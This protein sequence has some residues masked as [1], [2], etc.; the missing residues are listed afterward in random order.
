M[1]HPEELYVVKTRREAIQMINQMLGASMPV[2][3][4]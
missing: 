3:E 4:T 2:P 1:E